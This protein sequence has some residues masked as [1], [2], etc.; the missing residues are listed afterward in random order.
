MNKSLTARQLDISRTTLIR[1]YNEHWNAYI[2]QKQQVSS[3]AFD[4][5]SKKLLL[6]EDLDKAR[7]VFAESCHLA[8]QQMNTRL[9]VNP[10]RVKTNDLISYINTLLPYIADKKVVA[11]VIDG[12]EQTIT[13]HTT[14]IE[15]VMQKI[16]QINI[17]RSGK[18]VSK[19]QFGTDN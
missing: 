12:K 4:I 15:N 8:I 16:N 9:Q 19:G 5:E 18:E 11:G 14:F 10:E 2:E 13:P 7:A 1:Y 6:S 17:E 3:D